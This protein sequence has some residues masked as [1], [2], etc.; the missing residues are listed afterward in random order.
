M[1]GEMRAALL[2]ITLAAASLLGRLNACQWINAD[3]GA[4]VSEP[5]APIQ[6]RDGIGVPGTS[7]SISEVP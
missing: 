5:L 2:V 4:F 1:E 6:P 7:A 3:A